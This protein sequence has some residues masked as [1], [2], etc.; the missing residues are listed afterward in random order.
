MHFEERQKG[1]VGDIAGGN[2]EQPSRRFSE[3]VTVPEVAVF[4]DH[5]PAFSISELDDLTV[6]RAISVWQ[7]GGVAR[8]VPRSRQEVC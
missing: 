7:L 1:M 5:D 4:G 8:V 6:G 3:Q 2:D